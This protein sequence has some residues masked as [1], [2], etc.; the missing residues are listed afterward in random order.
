VFPDWKKLFLRQ[1]R[2]FYAHEKQFIDPWLP[3]IQS[4]PSSLQK[5]EWNCQGELRD[6]WSYVLQF[7][8]SGVRV[9][10]ATTSPSLVA[11]TSTQIPIIGWERR[12][13]SAR[14]C[15][16]LQSMGGLKYLPGGIGAFKAL[17]NAVNVTVVEKI[18]AKLL[19]LL[20]PDK[21]PANT[22]VKREDPVP[23]TPSPRLL[24]PS[25]SATRHASR[26]VYARALNLS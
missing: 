24:K 12:Y 10:R 19:P 17:G 15:A 21:H 8:A 9:K 25:I 16:R 14:E 20:P 5:F 2:E 11:M 1:N 3:K 26:S 6:I 4:F 18:L 23:K 13:M 7:R 22:V